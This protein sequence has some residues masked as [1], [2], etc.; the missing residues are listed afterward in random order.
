[1][2]SGSRDMSQLERDFSARTEG[3]SRQSGSRSFSG[4]QGRSGSA[5]GR[6]R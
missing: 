1:M 6:R 3:A 4:F 5:S 2:S